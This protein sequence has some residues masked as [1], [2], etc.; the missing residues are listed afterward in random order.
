M[1]AKKINGGSTYNEHEIWLD[2]ERW[3][4][5]NSRVH[6]IVPTLKPHVL[7]NSLSSLFYSH[8]TTSPC[9]VFAAPTH[10]VLYKR[11]GVREYLIIHRKM[12]SWKDT[13]WLVMPATRAGRL[14]LAIKNEAICI[15]GYGDRS[16][17]RLREGA[18]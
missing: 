13:D 17:G 7:V 16:L 6:C 15:S 9:K 10:I 11:F 12:K 4:I 18:T 8:F 5:I 1:P 3:E 2:G 14:R